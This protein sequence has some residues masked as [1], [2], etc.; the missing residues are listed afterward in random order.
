MKLPPKSGS[1]RGETKINTLLIDGNALFKTG[2][3]G[4]FR[5]VNWRGER[6]G[7]IYQFITVLRRFLLDDLYHRVI[8]FWDGEQ[9]GKLR[10]DIY[11]EY[12][13]GRGKDFSNKVKLNKEDEP[14]FLEQQ[15]RVKQYLEEL[16]IRQFEDTL[17]EGDDLIAHYCLNKNIN[18]NITICTN[19]GDIL[20]LLSD[21]I[22]VYLCN[23][24]IFVTTT[25]FSEHFNYHYKNV[26]TI[27][28]II[29]DYS[30][31]IK[32][33]TGVKDKT[34]L[35]YF[36]VLSEREVSINEI[37]RLADEIQRERTSKKLKPIVALDN[38]IKRVTTGSQ[39]KRIY[40]INN[41]LVD[42]KKPFITEGCVDSISELLSLPINPDGRDFKNIY[43]YIKQDDLKRLIGTNNLSEYLL[44]FKRLAYREVEFY[45]KQI[46]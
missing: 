36:P 37:V 46:I 32:G 14:D 3:H 21:D 34:L 20:Q 43:E 44:P 29:G 11:P 38:I 16:F 31:S 13:I 42:L 9:S 1:K 27:K 18:E 15:Y 7:G 33:I 5:E 8:V 12:K 28:T 30:D 26:V 25:N 24:K 41:L 19:D 45:N 35:K 40:E 4:A 17:V 6:I 23:K 22:R 2:Y 10:F 39:G